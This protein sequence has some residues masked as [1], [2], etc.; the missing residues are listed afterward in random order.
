M[1]LLYAGLEACQVL[2]NIKKQ[3]SKVCFSEAVTSYILPNHVES[4]KPTPGFFDDGRNRA[5]TYD[6]CY[7][8][9]VL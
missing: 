4:K 6:L 3:K 8:K 1:G 9:A 7:V 5:R 2:P